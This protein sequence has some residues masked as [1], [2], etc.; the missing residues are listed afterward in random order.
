M[1]ARNGSAFPV[2]EGGAGRGVWRGRGGGRC[3]TELN[4]SSSDDSTLASAHSLGV[5]DPPRPM[6]CDT[7]SD[8]AS[9]AAFHRVAGRRPLKRPPPSC[10]TV[11][12]HPGPLTECQQPASGATAPGAWMLAVSGES[13]VTGTQPGPASGPVLSR[14]GE[15]VSR[16]GGR[17]RLGPV[18]AA[19]DA[20]AAFSRLW[21]ESVPESVRTHNRTCTIKRG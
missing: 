6:I 18:C 16:M 14:P 20:A 10:A 13:P 19:T 4:R 1:W 17:F 5:A 12:M 8:S 11:A 15:P 3:C 9:A 2:A 7:P 21:G